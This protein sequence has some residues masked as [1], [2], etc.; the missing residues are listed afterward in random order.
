MRRP[1]RTGDAPIIPPSGGGER[2]DEEVQRGG[3]ERACSPPWSPPAAA[4]TTTRPRAR[5]PRTGKLE[6]SISVWI[7]DPGSPKI[8]GVV[9]QYGTDF[10]AANPGTKVDIQFVPWAQAHDKFVTAIAGGKV[11]DVAEMGTTWTPEF[12]DQ[13][14]FV[15]QREDRRG[16]V[17]LQPRRRR[18]ARRQGLGQA[19]VRGLAGTDLPQG[20]AREGRRRAAHDVGRDEGR[21]EGDQEQGAGHLPGRLH[22]PDRAH[23][24]AD[25][26]AGR[27]RDRQAGRRHVEGGAELA[28]GRRG[29]RLLRLV[30]QGRP[31]AQGRDRLGGA[32]RAD[33]VRQRRH[34][35]ARRGRLDLSGDHRHQ[36]GT[37]EE[38]RHRARARRA[39]R[40]HGVRRRQPPGGSRSPSR[41]SSQRRSSTSCSSRTS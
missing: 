39:E 20:R 1:L 19:L 35:D 25:D 26:L 7:M 37:G 24:P 41:P 18:D 8:Q 2:E 9:K 14:G 17:R 16:R 22:R 3:R 34:R 11:P 23:V 33:R 27:R 30:L 32:R 31:G 40:Q 5:P 28:A 6:G 10:E 38:D 21:G 12:A 29:D 36:A 13:G 15:E 4:G